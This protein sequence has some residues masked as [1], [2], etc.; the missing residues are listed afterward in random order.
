MY[1]RLKEGGGV[2]RAHG[3]CFIYFFSNYRLPTKDLYQALP[4]TAGTHYVE[5]ILKTE[6]TR[7]HP[8]LSARQCPGIHLILAA[9]IG[10]V[11]D[12]AC[13]IFQTVYNF[14]IS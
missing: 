12:L 10:V 14:S 6:D 9:V 13:A 11:V 7:C 8:S 3:I 4:T 5:T 1:E 2:V